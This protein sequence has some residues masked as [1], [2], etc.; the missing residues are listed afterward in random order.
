MPE[1]VV[2]ALLEGVG[3]QWPKVGQVSLSYVVE[4]IHPAMLD[5]TQGPIREGAKALLVE[6]VRW[7]GP[8][9]N[10]L[11]PASIQELPPDPPQPPVNK[12]SVGKGN[13]RSGLNS[14]ICLCLV[15]PGGAPQVCHCQECATHG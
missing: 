8:V 3:D 2:G 10:E 15:L 12:H 5:P 13:R 11:R 14:S 6:L 4:T 9:I 7:V 1:A